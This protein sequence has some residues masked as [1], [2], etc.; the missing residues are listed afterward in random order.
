MNNKTVLTAYQHTAVQCS[1]P[2]GLIILLYDGALAAL[3]TA[4]ELMESGEIEQRSEAI[5][6]ARRIITELQCSLDME[7]GGG[8]A[9]RLMAL[10]SYMYRRLIEADLSDDAG[11]LS[12]V[13]RLLEGLA[14]AWRQAEAKSAEAVGSGGADRASAAEVVGDGL[15]VAA[16]DDQ[17]VLRRPFVGAA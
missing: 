4:F 7:A 12:E 5:D 3:R 16:D 11:K 15:G 17:A 9:N 13:I 8:F 1:T 14:D 10:Y 6:K 2:L